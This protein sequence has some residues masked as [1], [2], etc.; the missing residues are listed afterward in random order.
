M[1]AF[2]DRDQQTGI[3]ELLNITV[4]SRARLAG[5]T[6]DFLKRPDRFRFGI[7]IKYA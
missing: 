4:G 7:E 2:A 1:R 5:L 6:R 3:A